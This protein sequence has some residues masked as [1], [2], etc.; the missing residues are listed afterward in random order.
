MPALRDG[1]GCVGLVPRVT[2]RSTL[3]Y[4]HILPN[5]RID[6]ASV[7]MKSIYSGQLERGSC[8]P[9]LPAVKLREGWGTRRRCGVHIPGPQLRATGGTLCAV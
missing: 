5:G 4:F 7:I 8:S 9:T 3:G 1:G 6:D 2:L